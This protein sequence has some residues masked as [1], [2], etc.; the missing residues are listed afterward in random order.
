MPNV[1]PGNVQDAPIKNNPL[2]KYYISAIVADF[3][4]NSQILQSR[5]QATQAANFVTLC[6]NYRY[7]DLKVHFS[8]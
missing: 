6:G 3:L 7:L 8:Q 5:I 1:L 2:G 4:L